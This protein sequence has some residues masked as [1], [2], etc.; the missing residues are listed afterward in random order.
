MSQ[1]T[2]HTSTHHRFVTKSNIPDILK[3]RKI[4]VQNVDI[5]I[6]SYLA[7]LQNPIDGSVFRCCNLPQTRRPR[8]APFTERCLQ[9]EVEF[10]ITLYNNEFQ[11]VA[12]D[13]CL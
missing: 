10:R 13:I 8:Y 5:F 11:V 12:L 6:I 2:K 7:Y 1:A 9:I 3:H 4:L